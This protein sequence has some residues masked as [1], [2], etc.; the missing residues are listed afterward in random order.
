MLVR[1]IFLLLIFD[2]VAPA[3][4]Q[5][6]FPGVP[7][8]SSAGIG[9]AIDDS[10]GFIK[11]LKIVPDSPAAASKQIAEKQHILAIGQED[12]PAVSTKNKKMLDCI[13]LIRGMAGTR[14]RLTVVPEGAPEYRTREVLLTRDELGN[15]LGLAPDGTL[16][17]VGK[18]AP[19]LTLKRL[20]DGQGTSLEDTRAGKIV[21]VRFWATWSEPSLAAMEELHKTAAQFF[22]AKDKIEFI[23]VCIDEAPDA[24]EKANALVKGKKWTHATNAWAALENHAN[25]HIIALPMTYVIGADGRIL[26]ADPPDLLEKVLPPLL[27]K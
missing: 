8:S 4:A 24:I 3:G 26:Q 17:E 10:E 5:V 6:I 21:V 12:Q 23:T 20:E 1:L 27:K 25:W 18:P 11:V 2:C 7:G 16:L 22:S 15:P 14:V 13:S 19:A 9:V